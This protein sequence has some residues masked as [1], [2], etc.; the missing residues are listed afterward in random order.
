MHKK[1]Y[2]VFDIDGTIARNSLLQLIVRELANRGHVRLATAISIEKMLNDY[3]LR[4]ADDN[5]GSY[6]KRAVDM[7]FQDMP[8]GLRVEEYD[9]AVQTVVSESITNTYLYTTELIKSLQ[10]KGYFMIAISGSEFRAVENF[11]RLFN[12]DA[13]LGA[14]KYEIAGGKITG[15]SDVV[16]YK[17]NDILRGMIHKFD[18]ETRGSLAVGDTSSDIPMLEMAEQPICFNP[19]QALFK[20]ARERGWMVVVERKDMVYG[21]TKEGDAYKV[22]QTNV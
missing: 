4:I 19:N 2:A 13:W 12:F 17:K 15:K 21:L 16:P 11:A 6:M 10:A 20:E 3:R 5:F 8:E 22:T 18:L 7:L 1:P 9:A 14:V